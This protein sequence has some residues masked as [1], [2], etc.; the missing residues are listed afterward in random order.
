MQDFSLVDRRVSICGKTNCGKSRLLK[1]LI[2]CEIDKFDKIYCFSGTENVNAYFTNSESGIVPKNQCF[3]SYSDDWVAK[4][5]ETM[6]QMN[7]KKANKDKKHVLIIL[8]DIAA[9]PSSALHTSNNFK[10]LC[11]MGRHCGIA[12]IVTSQYVNLVPPTFRTNVDYA[13][14]GQLNNKSVE[15]MADEYCCNISKK[16]FIKMY[17]NSTQNYYFL[18]YDNRNKKSNKDINCIYS[19]IRVPDWYVKKEEDIFNKDDEDDF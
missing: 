1:Y 11:T 10:K 6:I 14:V 5:I 17:E 3:E 2:E 12:L 15:L 8:D 19:K 9:D 16:D 4:L 18:M 13:F 7:G